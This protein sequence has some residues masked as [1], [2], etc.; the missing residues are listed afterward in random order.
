MV[1]E[2]K[3]LSRT[4]VHFLQIHDQSI[5]QKQMWYCA[6]QYFKNLGLLLKNGYY[7]NQLRDLSM[8]K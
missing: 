3:P 2:R 5:K 7:L 6:V 4:L 8:D 1:H